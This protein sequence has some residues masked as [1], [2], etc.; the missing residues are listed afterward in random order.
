MATWTRTDQRST[1]SVQATTE[2]AP[3]GEDGVNLDSVG[4]FHI[5]VSADAGQTFTGAVTDA[6]KAY[7][8][9]GSDWYRAPDLDFDVP[10]GAIGLQRFAVPGWVVAHPYNRLAHVASGVLVSLGGLTV[11]YEITEFSGRKL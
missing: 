2:S 4:G 9:I 7:V 10:A 3:T 8:R 11:K 5:G 1:T 6:F